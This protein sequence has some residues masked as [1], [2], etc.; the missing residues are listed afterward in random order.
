[1]VSSKAAQIMRR[2]DYGLAPGQPADLVVIDA[3]SEAAAVAEIA[4]VLHAFKRGRRTVT[5][6]PAVLHR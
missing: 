3:G 5:R 2:A 1:L 6:A 4:P